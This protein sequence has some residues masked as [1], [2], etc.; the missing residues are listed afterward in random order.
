MNMFDKIYLWHKLTLKEQKE[1]LKRP[2]LLFNKQVK[3]IVKSI[4]K[5]VEKNGDKA[6][7]Y[8]NNIFDKIN[9]KK[10]PLDENDF[11]KA[12]KNIKL[13]LKKSMLHA[14]MNIKK[15][16]MAQKLKDI[17]IEI[18]K[19]IKCQ[20][21]YRP[22]SSVGLYIPG[23]I[24]PLF[25]TVFMLAIPAVIAGCENIFLCSPPPIDEKIIYAAKICGIK[26][27][28]QIGGA[29]AIASF[30]LGTESIPKVDKIFGPGNIWVTEAKKQV[31]HKINIPI[32]ML[33]GPSE[34][35]VIADE[36][37]K[38]GFIAADLLSQLEHGE[39]VQVILLTTSKKLIF[40][41]IDEINKQIDILKNVKLFMIHLK[42][43]LT[44]NILT[45]I[46]IVNNYCPE[47]LI[48][49]TKKPRILINKIKNAS[50]IF[51][52]Q[53]SSESIGDYAS[54]TN[55]VLPTYGYSK[56]YSSLGLLDFQKR[57]TIQEINSHGFIQL[58][59]TV[60]TLA[61]AENMQAH[62]NAIVIRN[63]Y[64]QEKKCQQTISKN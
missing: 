57:I 16:H 15:F 6:L 58:S 50:S 60:T 64:L 24:A 27:I 30:A 26:K 39:N 41:V 40:L 28:F 36:N 14:F 42:F 7:H 20:Y 45:C 3:K 1:I 13:N 55:H 10:F 59:N 12:E 33:A 23:G 51:I 17:N 53:W 2:S 48:I 56:F 52:G 11:L 63:N 43:I 49:Q 54:G 37:A 4:I 61:E 21:V 31:N 32:D 47:H 35:M 9:V 29:Q 8:Y 18:Q 22:I 44:K 19:G 34:L 5:K 46:E 62:K 38:A 25:S